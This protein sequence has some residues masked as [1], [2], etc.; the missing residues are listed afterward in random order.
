MP[1]HIKQGGSWQTTRW[2]IKNGGSW[3]TA[4]VHLKVNGSWEPVSSE[5]IDNFE[6]GDASEWTVSGTGNRSIVSGLNGTGNAWQHDGF[7]RAHLA[8]ADAVD[9][10]P[11][12]GDIFEFWFRITSTSSGQVRGRFEFSADGTQ[13]DDM[14]RIEWER[15]T[16]DN[17]LAIEKYSGG[18]QELLD[19]DE[20][21]TASIDQTYRCE[22]HWN[23][24]DNAITAQLYHPDGSTASSQV[25]ISDSSSGEWAQPGIKFFTNDNHVC[26]Y[27]EVR[28]IE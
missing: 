5:I 14:Y 17:E 28:I 3:Q 8:G 13:D 1:I 25:S 21:F 7:T 16:S 23:V 11:Q 10:G 6:D 26:R 18:S 19:T 9:R 22:V 24:G 27:D 15:E 2:H 4:R 12:P 20:N